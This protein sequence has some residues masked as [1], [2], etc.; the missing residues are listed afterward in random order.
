MC[1]SFKRTWAVLSDLADPAAELSV[2]VQEVTAAADNLG[3]ARAQVV[4][5]YYR[6][7]IYILQY[8]LGSSFSIQVQRPAH[9]EQPTA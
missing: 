4:D 2:L 1:V 6:K 9:G 7:Y 3:L 8:P 5:P